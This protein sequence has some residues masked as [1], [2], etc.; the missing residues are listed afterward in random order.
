MHPD[1]GRAFA[2]A[3]GDEGPE[4]P[5]PWM[6]EPDAPGMR[7]RSFARDGQLSFI[8]TDLEELELVPLNADLAPYFG[9]TDGVLVI[10]VPKGSTLNL[11]GGDVLLQIDGRAPSN[12]SQVHRILR[13]YD[14]GNTVKFEV[15]RNKKTVTVTGTIPT[16]PEMK[17]KHPMPDSVKVQAR[18][19]T[20]SV[21][22]SGDGVQA[23]AII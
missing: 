18:P 4:G 17:W 6:I 23:Y 9:A 20:W 11:K 13:S 10:S 2:F 12:T 7:M 21:T 1:D 15:M 22:T 19:T 3:F 16:A 14:P 8:S 5:E